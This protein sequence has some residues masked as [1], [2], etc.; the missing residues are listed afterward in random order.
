V[1]TLNSI[2]SAVVTRNFMLTSFTD[3]DYCFGTD[4][5]LLN[6]IDN[7][8]GSLDTSSVLKITI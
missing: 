1:T 4:A 5:D 3:A 7:S 2:N 8:A 6:S